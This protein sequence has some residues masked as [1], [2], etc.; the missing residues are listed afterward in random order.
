MTA[1]IFLNLYMVSRKLSPFHQDAQ[2]FSYFLL[3]LF[4]PS[5]VSCLQPLIARNN[6]VECRR[7]VFK[8]WYHFCLTCWNNHTWG[9]QRAPRLPHSKEAQTKLCK[10]TT[11]RNHKLHEKKCPVSNFYC[12]PL[13]FNSDHSFLFDHI[14]VIWNTRIHHSIF[15]YGYSIIH[16]SPVTLCLFVPSPSGTLLL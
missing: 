10:E 1:M 5:L 16:T 6:T 11:W 9:F 14:L 7:L 15:V 4:L 2:S 12:N 8:S 13:I 3:P